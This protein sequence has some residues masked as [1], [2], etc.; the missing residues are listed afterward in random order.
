MSQRK[1]NRNDA[2]L[3]EVQRLQLSKLKLLQSTSMEMQKLR[4][5][6]R[7]LCRID[8]QKQISA[9]IL[10]EINRFNT[11]PAVHN[12]NTNDQM[13]ATTL[14]TYNDEYLSQTFT[15]FTELQQEIKRLREA[16][17]ALIHATNTEINSMR[18]TIK[19]LMNRIV[20][21]IDPNSSL[22]RPHA[23]INKILNEEETKT[24]EE[25]LLHDY[26]A[27]G[28]DD[29]VN[30]MLMGTKCSGKTVLLRNIISLYAKDTTNSLMN[31]I[32]NGEYL[33]INSI[34]S[35]IYSI[36]SEYDFF[37][38][39][40]YLLQLTLS[41][42]MK[43]AIEYFRK[44]R[45]SQYNGPFLTKDIGKHINAI[46]CTT[47][48]ADD[49]FVRLVFMNHS[50]YR[51]MC[52]FY[53]NIDK[54]CKSNWYSS[55]SEQELLLVWDKTTSPIYY[56]DIQLDSCNN[57]LYRF[58]DISSDVLDEAN[59]KYMKNWTHLFEYVKASCVVYITS[60]IFNYQIEKQLNGK[61][62]VTSMRKSM[63]YFQ[64]MFEKKDETDVIITEELKEF[65]SE[66]DVLNMA[67]SKWEL[68]PIITL[69]NK[70]DIF[71][72][73]MESSW[74]ESKTIVL[75]FPEYDGAQT[76]ESIMNYLQIIFKSFNMHHKRPYHCYETVVV[77]QE[78]VKTIV[79]HI[80]TMTNLNTINRR[81]SVQLNMVKAF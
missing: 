48:D 63:D 38:S 12:T 36:L 44:N 53:Q 9:E 47:Q 68:A 11:A 69:F 20:S 71:R 43:T 80:K 75:T 7:F 60:P 54:Y 34:I 16:K 65:D 4:A 18:D 73:D 72:M 32:K 28:K 55:A 27:L 77:D 81:L 24:S 33:I 5:F 26:I 78:K 21:K 39:N 74:D 30:I 66:E 45:L 22:Y 42:D 14:Q 8:Q 17:F 29:V 52:Y 46:F 64:N 70:C 40:K 67:Q 10:K 49:Q 50:Y 13:L 56:Y 58:W 3:A 57:I 41:E 35:S 61:I 76:Y 15:N 79:H 25:A 19:L 62:D 23:P 59:T 6:I 51:N 31:S 1:F 2:L 37:Q